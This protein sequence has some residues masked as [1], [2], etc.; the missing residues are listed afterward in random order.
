[1]DLTQE[2]LTEAASKTKS[3]KALAFTRLQDRPIESSL[4]V[5]RARSWDF[6]WIQ[7]K[8]A[9]AAPTMESAKALA[10]TRLQDRPIESSLAVERAKA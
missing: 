10:F 6:P 2:R 8:L 3:A 5:E 7:A 9:D 4:A 1:L